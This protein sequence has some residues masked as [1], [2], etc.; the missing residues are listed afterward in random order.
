[1]I[2]NFKKY[3]FAVINLVLYVFI[4]SLYSNKE[5]KTLSANSNDSF[6]LPI[7]LNNEGICWNSV[8]KQF[9]VLFNNFSDSL[10]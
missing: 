5:F 2:S 4:F 3:I 9:L 8:S 7:T 1:M 10:P 6:N